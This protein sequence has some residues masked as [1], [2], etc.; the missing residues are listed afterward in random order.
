MSG[1]EEM[2]AASRELSERSFFRCERREAVAVIV[3]VFIGFLFL[4]VCFLLPRQVR[5]R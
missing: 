3:R 2:R 5:P 4:L 1:M